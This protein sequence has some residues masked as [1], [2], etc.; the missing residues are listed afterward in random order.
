MTFDQLLFDSRGT[1]NRKQ[2]W[3]AH[4]LLFPLE[5]GAAFLFRVHENYLCS[6]DPFTTLGQAY[7]GALGVMAL[8]FFFMWYCVVIKRLRA[9]GR[10]HLSFFA[11]AIPILVTLTALAPHFPL[12]CSVGIGERAIYLLAILPFWLV[13]F[14]DLGVRKGKGERNPN[15]LAPSPDQN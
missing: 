5:I 4:L 13:Y 7:Y 1:I 2:F 6:M 14:I 8:T 10:G 15:T 11:Y 12:S 9:S 3:I